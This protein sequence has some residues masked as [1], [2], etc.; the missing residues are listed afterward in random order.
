[1]NRRKALKLTAGVVGGTIIGSEIFLTG[2]VNKEKNTG[3]FS[4]VD[5]DLLDEV[6]ET[7][8]P[9]TDRSPGAKE[10]KIGEFMKVIVLDCYSPK[11]QE[12]F[13]NGLTELKRKAFMGQSPEERFNYL[14]QLDK[15][16]R[17][18]NLEDSLHFFPMLKQLTLWGY[19]TS[20]PGATKA[21]RYNPIP[22]EYIG[23]VPYKAGD[24]AWATR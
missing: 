7:I 11:E 17:N 23:C 14:A 20:E 21:L 22:G 8:L 24:R 18:L 19:F 13:K 10:A 3:L 15:E 5:I 6:G 12:V 16:T 9:K 4:K 2:C 1:M